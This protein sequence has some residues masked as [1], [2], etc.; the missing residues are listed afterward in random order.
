MLMVSKAAIARHLGIKPP[1]ITRYTQSGM[2]VSSLADAEAW[3]DENIRQ[4]VRGTPIAAE[5]PNYQESRARREAAEAD[6]A[7]QKAAQ[8]RRELVSAE[9]VKREVSAQAGR[10]REALLQLPDRLA[11][12]L[13]QRPLGFIRDTLDKEIRASLQALVRSGWA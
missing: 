4:K 12:L 6:I 8:L 1:L 2:P 11:P 5:I 13:E 3:Y 10:V 9:D 7:E